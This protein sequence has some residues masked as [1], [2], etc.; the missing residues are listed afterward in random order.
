MKCAAEVVPLGRCGTALRVVLDDEREEDGWFLPT[1][2]LRQD[3]ESRALYLH[4]RKQPPSTLAD[5]H[6]QHVHTR[7]P[8]KTTLVRSE[9]AYY[10]RRI[11]EPL[12][13]LIEGT[14]HRGETLL[15]HTS[16]PTFLIGPKTTRKNCLR[17]VCT[18]SI[19]VNIIYTYI[20]LSVCACV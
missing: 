10:L 3:R 20:H 14:R 18:F 4:I 2:G 11:P 16:T 13:R 5:T 12:D 1:R 6:I 8:S 9:R 15:A 19:H 7:T 17:Y